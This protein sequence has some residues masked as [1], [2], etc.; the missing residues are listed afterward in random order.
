[1]CCAQEFRRDGNDLHISQT[2][3]LVEALCGFQFTLTHLDGRHL[4]IKYPAGKVIEP[5]M[6]KF[7]FILMIQSNH[8]SISCSFIIKESSL[9]ASL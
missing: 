8:D 7:V 2:I 3:G 4:L 1:M 9:I 6:Y 5:G